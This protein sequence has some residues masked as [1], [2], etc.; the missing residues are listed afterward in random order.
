MKYIVWAGIAA[1]IIGGGY[2]AYTSFMTEQT[3]APEQT[4]EQ[5][6]PQVQAQDATVGDG[7]EAAPGTLVSVLYTGRFTDGTVFDSSAA[8]NNE[9]LA[10][11][12]GAQG[13]IPGFQIGVN[14][15][16]VGGKRTMV[17]PPEL[18]YGDQDIKDG[19]GNIIIPA[20][21]TLVFD[22][23]LLDVTAAPD[24]ETGETAQ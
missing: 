16:K 24:Q 10:F 18:G 3:P 8:H 15:M 11:V 14:G 5:N 9:P 22:V 21:S 13:L 20:Q 6:L 17:I 23:E 4:G 2:F 19:E 1:V 7:A 12:L